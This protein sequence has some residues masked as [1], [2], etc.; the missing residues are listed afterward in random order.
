MKI[1]PNTVENKLLDAVGV[2][3]PLVNRY[4]ILNYSHYGSGWVHDDNPEHDLAE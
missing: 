4:D 3:K 1:Y 2:F